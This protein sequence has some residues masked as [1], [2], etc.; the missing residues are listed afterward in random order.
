MIFEEIGTA[1]VDLSLQCLRIQV[2]AKIYLVGIRD[3][4]Q[5]I[6]YKREISVFRIVETPIPQ[7]ETKA[8]KD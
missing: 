7:A 2:D 3:L 4:E 5:A 6:Q 8:K 1:Q